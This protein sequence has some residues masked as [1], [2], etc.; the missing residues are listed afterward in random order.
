MSDAPIRTAAH[1]RIPNL[2]CDVIEPLLQPAERDCLRYIIRHTIGYVDPTG[3]HMRKQRDVIAIDQFVNGIT[4][5]PYLLDLGCGRGRDSVRSGL[6]G[7]E[8]KG[9]VDV[10]YACLHCEWEQQKDE[11]PPPAKKGD[12]PCCPYCGRTCS[13][14]WALAELTPAKI[15]KLLNEL[16]PKK[17]TWRWDPEVQRFCFSSSDTGK[18]EKVAAQD[19]KEEAERMRSLMWYPELVEKAVELAEAQLKSGRKITDRRRVNNFYRPVY[20]LQQRYA[21]HP[22]LV[23]YALEQ[24]LKGPALRRPD[25]KSWHKYLAKVAQNNEH[26]FVHGDKPIPGTN[27]AEQHAGSLQA[28]EREIRK[29]LARAYELNRDG[30]REAAR[31]LLADMLSQTKALAPLFG[32]DERRCEE[33]LRLAFKQ[34]ESDFVSVRYDPWAA[35]DYYPEWKPSQ[36]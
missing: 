29:L 33:A 14:S 1:T 16:D 17:R 6:K 24:T 22:A 28:R 9:L 35:A 3:R 18:A 11:P 23:R 4:F 36:A 13:R 7:L 32:G 30:E 34:G 5:G 27:A 12:S 25:T 20:E 2:I 31:A 26:R 10:R 19:W 21:S 8:D 15:C